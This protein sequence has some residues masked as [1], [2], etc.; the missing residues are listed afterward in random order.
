MELREN[1][2]E[3][4]SDG[5]GEEATF[6]RITLTTDLETAVSG[7]EFVTET[8]V[9]QQ[10]I[11]QGVFAD[12]DD[13]A[14]EDAIRATKTSGRNITEFAEPTSEWSAMRPPPGGPHPDP[15]PRG[16]SPRQRADDLLKPDVRIGR[17][18]RPRA[19]IGLVGVRS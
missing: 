11:K 16:F 8:T 9:E 18:H 12:P 5:S 2:G 17:Q 7:A 3:R 13:L 19:N 6:D 4:C 1:S 10:A 15:G 14:S